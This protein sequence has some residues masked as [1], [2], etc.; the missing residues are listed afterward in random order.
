M[1]HVD[2]RTGSEPLTAALSIALFRVPVAMPSRA[3]PGFSLQKRQ[4]VIIWMTAYKAARMEYSS[5]SCLIGYW[6]PGRLFCSRKRTLSKKGVVL[7]IP[8]SLY[9]RQHSLHGQIMILPGICPDILLEELLTTV[10]VRRLLH[11]FKERHLLA[12]RRA[13]AAWSQDRDN[14]WTGRRRIFLWFT[15]L[16]NILEDVPCMP[17]CHAKIC[18]VLQ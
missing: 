6:R 14:V 18:A 1:T 7:R 5:G 3:L 10:H 4:T 15:T 13:F 9:P 12:N 2:W 8:V 11:L 16:N 17:C